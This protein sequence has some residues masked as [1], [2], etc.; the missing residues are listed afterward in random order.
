M[1]LP[2]K[3]DWRT[4]MTY[5][6]QARLRAPGTVFVFLAAEPPRRD[7]MAVDAPTSPQTLAHLYDRVQLLPRQYSSIAELRRTPGPEVVLYYP[8][9]EVGDTS[10]L[11]RGPAACR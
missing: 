9:V 1:S 11:D 3:T 10:A 8:G 7:L 4:G 6:I 5:L 2:Y